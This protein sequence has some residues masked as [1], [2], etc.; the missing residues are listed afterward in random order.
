[1][2]GVLMSRLGFADLRPGDVLVAKKSGSRFLVTSIPGLCFNIA[3]LSLPPMTNPDRK[4]IIRET[5]SFSG[6]TTLP[7]K[8][9]RFFRREEDA[10]IRDAV[11]SYQLALLALMEVSTP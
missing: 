11:Q 3:S 6:S 8:E 9:L 5:F 2:Q 1:M 10:S 7:E 4:R